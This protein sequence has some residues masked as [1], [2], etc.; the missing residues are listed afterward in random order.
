MVVKNRSLVNIF[1]VVRSDDRPNLLLEAE[2][3]GLADGLDGAI[4]ERNRAEWARGE[5]SGDLGE[6][7]HMRPFDA[8]QC[9]PHAQEKK[10]SN[11]D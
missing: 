11:I 5:N 2:G 10:L 1:L 9:A 8:L 4:L 7:D 3:E 6:K